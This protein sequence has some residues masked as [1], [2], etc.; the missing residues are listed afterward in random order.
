M[1]LMC[2]SIRIIKVVVRCEYSDKPLH[3]TGLMKRIHDQ[4][5]FNEINERFEMSTADIHFGDFCEVNQ[6]FINLAPEA[7]NLF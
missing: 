7:C 2:F 6:R 3:K 5:R 1:F 4:I